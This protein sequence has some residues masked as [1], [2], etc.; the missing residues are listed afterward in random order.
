LK[1][2]VF[3]KL[4]DGPWGGGNQFLKAL[5]EEFYKKGYLS[6]EISKADIVLFNSHQELNNIVKM[7]KKYPDKIYIHRLDGPM[8]YRGR[9]GRKLD[10][11]I[12]KINL[13]IA[14]GTIY[15]SKWSRDENYKSG[16]SKN[17][18]ETVIHNAPNPAIFFPNKNKKIYNGKRKLK[19]ISTSWSNNPIKGFD[20]YHYLDDNYDFNKCEMTFIGNSDKPF[21]NIK[22]LK[23]LP[24]VELAEQLRQ[25]D[26][27]IFASK[28]EACSNSLLE[29]LHCGLPAVV[30]NLSSNPEILS[31]NG[32]LFDGYNVIDKIE[33][34]INNFQVYEKIKNIFSISEIS[35]KYI[36]FFNYVSSSFKK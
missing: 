24:S 21:K 29:A 31:G 1:V 35:N 23:P 8:S 14:D 4:I 26:F 17:K 6:T 5:S 30:R 16:I 33:E 12:I 28:I 10:K 34:M 27:F 18:Y 20:I 13:K 22:V 11:K 36:Q 7:K 32:V 25:H 2:H 19:M 15:Q 9:I 3:Y